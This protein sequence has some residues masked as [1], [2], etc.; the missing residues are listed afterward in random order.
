MKSSTA[1][2]TGFEFEMEGYPALAIINTDLRNINR[3]AYPHSVFIDLL[4]ETYN[5]NGHP[6]EAE[7]D[8]LVEVEKKMIDYLEEQTQTVHV[9]HTT[10]YRKREII[11]YTGE[12]EKVE[13]FLEYFL[14]TV[15]REHNFEIERDA[16][17]SNVAGFYE[18]LDDES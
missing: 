18:L 7:Y 8:Y 9:G 2:Y 14:T 6:E 16:E 10:V 3:S 17:W 12:P 15:E 5:E 11:F 4:P 1:T 13:G